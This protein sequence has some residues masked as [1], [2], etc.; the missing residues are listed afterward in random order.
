ME[1]LWQAWPLRGWGQVDATQSP[2]KDR[3]NLFGLWL[4]KKAEAQRGCTDMRKVR[5]GSFFI[6][7]TS[8]KSIEHRPRLC[9]KVVVAPPATD[10]PQQP[11]GF[12]DAQILV[13][14][15]LG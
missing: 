13:N 12:L 7:V 15:K 8:P 4:R 5:S 11:D 3:S 2:E 9:V 14:D 1:S 6:A 10:A